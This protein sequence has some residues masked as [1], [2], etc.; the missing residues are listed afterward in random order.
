MNYFNESK[1]YETENKKSYDKINMQ[2]ASENSACCSAPMM[3]MP[4][5]GCGVMPIYE[6]PQE[7]VC[8]RYICYDVPQDCQFMLYTKYGMNLHT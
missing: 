4:G 2:M 7:R 8:H 1:T 5:Y 6:C 3:D